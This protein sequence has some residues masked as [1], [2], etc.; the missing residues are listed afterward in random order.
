MFRRDIREEHLLLDLSIKKK[1]KKKNRSFGL[2]EP[3]VSI[4]LLDIFF[5]FFIILPLL[6]K[7]ISLVFFVVIL[8]IFL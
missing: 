6:L 5:V 8:S 7:N 4:S 2:V 3:V 1:T